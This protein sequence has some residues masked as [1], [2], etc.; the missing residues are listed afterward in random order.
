MDPSWIH[1]STAVAGVR[2]AA[3]AAAAGAAAS[4]ATVR[5]YYVIIGGWRDICMIRYIQ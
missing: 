4:A 5:T 1:G 2:A 3:V